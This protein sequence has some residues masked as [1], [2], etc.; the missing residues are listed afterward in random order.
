MPIG[1]RLAETLNK[2]CFCIEVNKDKLHHSLEAHLIDSGLSA[3]L[4]DTHSNLFA[5]SPVFLWSGH[6][7]KMEQLIRAVESISR[8]EAYREIVLANASEYLRQDPGPRGVFYGYDF[9]L[10]ADGPQ[11]IEINTNAGG[12]LLNLYLAAAQQACCSAVTRFFGGNNN[13]TD[14]E[15]QIIQMFR[16][17][18]N[19]QYPKSDLR[20]IAIVDNEP[21]NQFLY[22]EFLLFQSLF[23]RHGIE[24]IIADPRD[25]SINDNILYSG[26][27]K[28]DL[29]Y[30]RLTDFYLE[31]PETACLREAYQQGLAVFTP[32]PHNYAL[33]ADKRNLTLLSNPERLRE[34]GIEEESINILNE[35]L[36]RT[37]NVTKDNA[38]Q[39]W[40]D[41]KQL[42]FK[43]AIGYGSRGTYRGA[44]LTKRV[45]EN[46]I[47]NDYIAQAVIP[48]SE[49]QLK[50]NGEK[51]LLKMDI[52][53]VTYNASIQQIS[54]RLYQGQT[55]N[56]RTEGGGLATVF[57]TPE[58][59]C[60][61]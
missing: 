55:T 37:V 21:N 49:R 26:G 13:F 18:F 31:M 41:R 23:K 52:R 16:D 29:V 50:I 39:L 60:C 51:Q 46:I 57:A 15:N 59:S 38:E 45:W 9:H 11:L 3:H 54:A 2:D 1:S 48:P 34:F 30:N 7:Q 35:V 20:T 6:I 61:E 8:N 47:N 12:I 40:R 44:K 24:T 17:E 42:F 4:L 33:Y 56:L 10:G 32:S 28:I 36:P 53:C 27:Q 14:A 58:G 19:L 43:P 25:F 5:D 22:P